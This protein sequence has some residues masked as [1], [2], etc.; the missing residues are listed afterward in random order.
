MVQVK[1]LSGKS[2]LV[3][4]SSRGFGRAAAL[5]FAALGANVAVNYSS[6]SSKAEAQEVVDAIRKLGVRSLA[7]QADV[8][9]EESVKAMVER[10]A[11][12]FD[13][14]DI[15][16][17]NAGAFPKKPGTPT[18]ELGADEW[19]WLIG[20]NLKG[21]FLCTKHVVKE[22]VKR[23]KGGRIVNV[24]SIAGHIG[25]RSGCHYG[26]SK[27]GVIGLTRGWADE[28]GK[29]GIIVNAVAPG[30]VRTRLTEGL[31]KERWDNWLAGTPTGKLVGVEDIADAIVFLATAFGVNGQVLIVDNGYV[32]H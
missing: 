10:V 9:D 26:A 32:K 7:V 29:S 8:A 11:G 25:S 28:F 21:V 23:G 6:A 13:G 22:M 4:G 20:V 3:T 2:V 17:N 1:Q 19:D 30:P 15:L 16:V 12:E 31:P 18:T 27:A 5:K 24:S 14:I